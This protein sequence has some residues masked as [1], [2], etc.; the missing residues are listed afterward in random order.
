M[1]ITSYMTSCTYDIIYAIMHIIAYG[2]IYDF[3]LYS[4]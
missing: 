2:I 3:K 1:H 4:Y